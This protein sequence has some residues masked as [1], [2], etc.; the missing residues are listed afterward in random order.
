MRNRRR[1]GR[2][3]A[4][5]G[6]AVLLYR[7]IVVP[8]EACPV[9]EVG[10]AAGARRRVR[11]VSGRDVEGRLHAPDLHVSPGHCRPAG[12]VAARHGRFRR[13]VRGRAVRGM[14]TDG[15]IRRVLG[16]GGAIGAPLAD[17][18]AAGSPSAATM[19]AAGKTQYF[20]VMAFCLSVRNFPARCGPVLKPW[21]RSG[22]RERRPG[23]VGP[24][25]RATPTVSVARGHVNTW[26]PLRSGPV[27]H[28]RPFSPG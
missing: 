21:R 20:L 13:Q 10:I 16:A 17:A 19:T 6:H 18:A 1:T 7:G 27:T 28:R 11:A 15:S 12:P 23:Y 24:V 14:C 9:A 22:K 26:L 5:G 25:P 2:A 4:V 8:V 3:L